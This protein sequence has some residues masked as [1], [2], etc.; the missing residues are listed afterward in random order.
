MITNT[1]LSSLQQLR[2]RHGVQSRDDLEV[3]SNGLNMFG[4]TVGLHG[5]AI[6]G[7]VSLLSLAR[8]SHFI[9]PPRAT[10]KPAGVEPA[11]AAYGASL[12]GVAMSIECLKGGNRASDVPTAERKTMYV[13]APSH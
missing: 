9:I 3:F 10:H 6:G 7:H 1:C 2:L 12:M 4:S 5:N 11:G 13:P 8:D